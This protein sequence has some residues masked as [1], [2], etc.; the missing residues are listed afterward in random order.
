MQ[1][2]DISEAK[3][4]FPALLEAARHGAEIIIT[5]NAQPVVRLAHIGAVATN[6]TPVLR[7]DEMDA[8]GAANLF[9]SDHL[10]DR[11]CASKPAWDKSA[12]CWRVPVVLA[13]PHLGTLGQVGEIVVDA[14]S[15]SIRSH[16]P[17]EEMRQA[18]TQLIAQHYDAI[19]APLS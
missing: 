3:T 16:T 8:Q 9:L 11:I 13:Y 7:I 19:A 15:A 17:V 6:G 1:Q 2:I 10:P 18:A 12:Q 14:L 5:E 4:Q